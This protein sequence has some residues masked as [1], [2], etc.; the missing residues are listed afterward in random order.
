MLSF[1]EDLL[2]FIWQYKLLKPLPLISISGKAITIIKYGELNKDSGPDFF[3]AQIK[4]D[5]IVLVGNIELHLK[6]S[7]WLKH[8]HQNNTVYD[9]L[10]LHVVYEHDVEISQN[11]DNNVEVVELKNLIDQKIILNYAQLISSKTDLACF[12][13]IQFVNSIQFCSWLQRMA[14]ERL[15]MK[16]NRIENLFQ[17]FNGD[18]SQ[19]FYT[20]LLSNFGFKVN[21]LPF[22]LLSKQLPLTI[23]LKQAD[24]LMALEALLLGCSGFLDGQFE[25]KY[26]HQLQNEFD[27]FKTKYNLIPLNKSV[28]KFNKMRPANFPTLRLVQFALLIHQ[29]NAFILSPQNYLTLNDI[30]SCLNVTPTHYFKNHYQLDGTEIEKDI[31]FGELSKENIIINSIAPFFFFYS[32]KLAIPNYSDLAIELLNQCSFEKNQKTKLFLAKKQQLQNAAD[33]QGLINLYDNYCT[34]KQCL[35]CGIGMDILKSR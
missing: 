16:V 25:D 1:G 14:I 32:K 33:S 26:I 2:Q 13:Q 11:A 6:T 31:S 9:T 22:E 8:K 34:K 28:F 15:E 23:L 27:Y 19:T 29:Q 35:K 10:I 20:L 24:N 21:A 3:N 7:D 18:Y 4:M 17:Q 5:G 12:N 30:K